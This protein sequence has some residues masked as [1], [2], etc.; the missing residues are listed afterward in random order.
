MD[1]N[2]ERGPR[3]EKKTEGQWASANGDSFPP[4]SGLVMPL[5]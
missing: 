5:S 2:R 4:H 3:K 1:G